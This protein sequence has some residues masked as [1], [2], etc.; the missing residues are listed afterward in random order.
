MKFLRELLSDSGSISAVRTM[1]L[2]CCLSAVWIALAG[3][4]KSVPDYQGI[5]LLCGT[6]LSA[7]FAG[8]VIQKNIEVKS[9]KD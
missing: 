6:F 7:G 8:K 5:S 1:S 4:S 3:I 2:I 9:T